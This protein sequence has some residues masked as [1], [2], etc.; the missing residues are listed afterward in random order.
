M[1]VEPVINV[2]SII[3]CEAG[4][5]FI[6]FTGEVFILIAIKFSLFSERITA[7]I[8]ASDISNTKV[9][10]T[11]SN[12]NFYWRMFDKGIDKR[13][14]LKARRRSVFQNLHENSESAFRIC[15]LEK[16]LKSRNTSLTW[17]FARIFKYRSK[18][19]YL[20]FIL[21]PLFSI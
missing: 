5:R 1:F 11:V 3:S 4:Q 9:V 2:R 16:F 21:V 8:L 10:E 12:W 20:Q 19:Q 17:R 7:L 6:E 13:K 18:F 14:L 15:F